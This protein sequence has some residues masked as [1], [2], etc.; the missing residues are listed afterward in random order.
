[1]L[2]GM[3]GL[4]LARAKLQATGML[5]ARKLVARVARRTL[6][7]SAILVPVD[8]GYLRASGKQN[9]GQ[10]G[11][12]VV[13]QVEYTA[14][15]AA[16]VHN[17]RRALTIRPRPGRGPNARLKFQVG[18]RTVYARQVHQ[19][20]REGRPFLTTALRE[21]ARQEGFSYRSGNVGPS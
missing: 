19:P 15:Y 11:L 2:N 12:T 3:A 21:V 1:M 6:N 4:V 7:R 14:E 5:Q 9:I 10:R 8:T 16:A 20:A 17:G 18:G 13:G